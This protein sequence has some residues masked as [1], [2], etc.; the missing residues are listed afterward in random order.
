MPHA[1]VRLSVAAI[2][3]WLQCKDHGIGYP[4]VAKH[5][6]VR[7]LPEDQEVRVS[8]WCEERNAEHVVGSLLTTVLGWLYMLVSVLCCAMMCPALCCLSLCPHKHKIQGVKPLYP[9]HV[10]GD[11]TSDLPPVENYSEVREGGSLEG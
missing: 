10:W 6:Q 7:A 5:S 8:W 2:D 9:F 11:V 3:W 4:A 1:C